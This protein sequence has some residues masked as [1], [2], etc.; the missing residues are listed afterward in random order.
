MLPGLRVAPTLLAAGCLAGWTPP[1][2]DGW[3]REAWFVWTPVD[4]VAPAGPGQ[5]WTWTVPEGVSRI[6]VSAWGAGGGGSVTRPVLRTDLGFR[7]GDGGFVLAEV[8]VDPGDTLLIVPGR[9]GDAGG[10][11]G[12]GAWAAEDPA[13]AW[14]GGGGPG[15]PI[16]GPD[17]PAVDGVDSTRAPIGCRPLVADAAAWCTGAGAG[18]GWSGVFLGADLATARPDTALAVAAGGG[19]AGAGGDGGAGGGLRGQDAPPCGPVDVRGAAGASGREDAPGIAPVRALRLDDPA[20]PAGMAGALRG[21]SGGY[22]VPHMALGV[23]GTGI[24]GGG[25]GGG[26][27]FGGAGGVNAAPGIPACGGGGGSSWAEGPRVLTLPGDAPE[28]P[29]PQEAGGRGGAPTEPGQGGA[30]RI[31]W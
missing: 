18:G 26:G 5:A 11:A 31:Q 10:S 8:D 20:R 23:N 4:E 1:A 14:L 13:L 9:G 15:A 16:T 6:A 25:G 3:T 17:L 27:W 22:A 19:G 2:P 12:T 24:Q 21:G 29:D 7:G 28:R 30:V